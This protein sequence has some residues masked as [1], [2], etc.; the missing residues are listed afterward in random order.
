MTHATNL[1]DY[2][3]LN[4][5]LERSGLSFLDVMRAVEGNQAPGEILILNVVNWKY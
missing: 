1:K 2:E 5:K 3:L 4:G